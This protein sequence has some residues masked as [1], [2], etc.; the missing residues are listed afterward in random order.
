M[1]SSPLLLNSR[2]RKQTIHLNVI[3]QP[4]NYANILQR[5]RG[6]ETIEFCVCTLGKIQIIDLTGGTR[7]SIDI[8]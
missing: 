4:L 6:I 2:V 8:G 3:V 1:N 7:L 5:I